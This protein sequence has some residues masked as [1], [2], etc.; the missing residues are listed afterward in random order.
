VAEDPGPVATQTPKGITVE[1]IL[2]GYFPGYP[3]PRRQ[4]LAA[5]AV[6]EFCSV[7]RGHFPWPEN[8]MHQKRHN[9]LLQFDSQ[10]I[11]WTVLRDEIVIQFERDDTRNPPWKV[12]IL[13][14]PCEE[15]NLYAYKVW[16][17]CFQAGEP[18]DLRLPTPAAESIPADYRKLGYDVVS[19]PGGGYLGCCPLFCNEEARTQP[20]NPYCLLDEITPALDLARFCSTTDWKPGP[21]YCGRGN[22]GPFCVVEVW[23]KTKPFA[24]LKRSEGVFEWPPDLLH[25]LVQHKLGHGRVFE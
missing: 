6:V 13:R 19:W 21:H 1:P 25:R 12:E 8:W 2:T 5:P 9:A 20:V 11:A 7:N 24:D 10:E 4:W 15:F 23:R 22:P 16:P 18:K 3:L 17:V 14:L